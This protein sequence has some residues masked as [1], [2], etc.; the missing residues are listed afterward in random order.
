MRTQTPNATYDEMVAFRNANNAAYEAEEQPKK[1]RVFCRL[2]ALILAI[3]PIVLFLI[4]ELKVLTHGT[5][6]VL[7][8]YKLLDLVTKLFTEDGFATSKLFGV[9]PLMVPNTSVLGLAG[10]LML[11]LIPVSMVVCLITAIVALFS[12]KAAPGCL[13]FIVFVEFG[14]YAGYAISLILPYLFYG[15]DFMAALDYFVLGIAGVAL[16]MY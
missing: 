2:L 11:Y 7:E 8:N 9:L 5:G 3:A 16:L 4:K 14:V 15:M 12:G 10:S 1:R 13:R 6:F